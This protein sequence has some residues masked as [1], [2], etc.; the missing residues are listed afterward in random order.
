MLVSQLRNV[1]VSDFRLG[2][3]EAL[4]PGFRVSFVFFWPGVWFVAPGFGF[5][6]QGLRAFRLWG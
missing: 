2:P 3:F 1:D 5:A 6:A 4:V